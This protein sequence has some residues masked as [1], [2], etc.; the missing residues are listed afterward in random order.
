MIWLSEALAEV[1]KGKIFSHWSGG[2]LVFDSR[3]IEEGDIFIALPGNNFDGHNFVEMALTEKK[4]AGAIVSILPEKVELHEKIL[5]VDDTLKSLEKL[6]NYK[7]EKSKAKIIAVTGS[8][9]KTSVKEILGLA[10]SPLG[11]TFISRGNYNNFLGVPINMASLPDDAEF[12]IFEIGMDH[13]G[14]ISPLTKLVKPHLAIITSIENIHR[15]NFASI[16]AIAMAKA[17][18]FEGLQAD[19]TAI[20]NA[21]SNCFDLLISVLDNVKNASQVLSLGIDSKIEDYF[22]RDNC[23][24]AKLNILNEEANIEFPYIL[25]YHQMGNIV[26]ALT[27]VA[28][29]ALDWRKSLENVKHFTLPRGRGMVTKVNL[30][31]KRITLI[32][33]SYNAGPVSVKAA[34]RTLGNYNGRKIAILGDMVDL[35]EESVEMHKSLKEDIIN[36]NIDKVICF[37][38]QMEDL[39]NILPVGKRIASIRDLKTLAKKLPGYLKS[40]DVLLIKGSY[41]L[42]NLY[43]FVKHLYED[44]LDKI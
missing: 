22:I 13:A 15:A 4:A 2:K 39:Y 23:S 31:G 1:T 33:D 34:L 30:N 38:K 27:S 40:D 21:T 9:G 19:S 29:F 18:I 26:L 28:S 25:P 42:T 32:D 12:A 11:K 3:L 10:F 20:I 14:E 16:E 5:L 7:R 44:S 6:A 35:G 24:F 37:G 17:E 36:N 43:G 41:Y 8:V